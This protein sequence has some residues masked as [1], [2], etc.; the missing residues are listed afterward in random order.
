MKEERGQSKK[1]QRKREGAIEQERVDGRKKKKQ[2]LFYWVPRRCS[3]TG[4]MAGQSAQ[5]PGHGFQ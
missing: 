5:V 3:H 4:H 1:M 2:L